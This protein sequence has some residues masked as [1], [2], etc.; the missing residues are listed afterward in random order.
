MKT[1]DMLVKIVS[2]GG[3][4][5]I[6]GEKRTTDSLVKIAKATSKRQVSLQIYNVDSKTTDMLVR[7][8]KA[9]EGRVIFELA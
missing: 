5:R 3:G 1:T 9:G 2:N 8:A 6:D 4:I 7:I